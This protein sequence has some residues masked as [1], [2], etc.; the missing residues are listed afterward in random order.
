MI[1]FANHSRQ[2]S[3]YGQP[4]NLSQLKMKKEEE[5]AFGEVDENK[6]EVEERKAVARRYRKLMTS[7]RP[8]DDRTVEK[9][10]LDFE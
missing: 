9:L 5:R 8:S 2:I 10:R 3:T 1:L 6:E 4:K 7:S